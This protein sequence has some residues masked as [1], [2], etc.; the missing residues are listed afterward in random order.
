MKGEGA[1]LGDQGFHA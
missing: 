1:R